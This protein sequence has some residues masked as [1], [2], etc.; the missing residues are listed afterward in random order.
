MIDQELFWR[1][2][3]EFLIVAP[4]AVIAFFPLHR[5]IRDRSPF[6]IISMFTVL[7]SIIAVCSMAWTRYTI[8]ADRF[9]MI[10]TPGSFP[11]VQSDGKERTDQEDL[12][13]RKC[14]PSW[15]LLLPVFQIPHGSQG[16]I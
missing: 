7:I 9:F 16:T 12:L 2:F 8:H 1:Y 11:A 14:F 15:E 13:F 10:F 6:G 4:C 5:D 3:L